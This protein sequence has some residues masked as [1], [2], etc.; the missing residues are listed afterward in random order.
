[1]EILN[2]DCLPFDVYYFVDR[3]NAVCPRSFVAYVLPE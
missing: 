3:A 1:V 2:F